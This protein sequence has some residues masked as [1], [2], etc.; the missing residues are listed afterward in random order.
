MGAEELRYLQVYLELKM[1]SKRTRFLHSRLPNNSVIRMLC[2]PGLPQP[3]DAVLHLLHLEDEGPSY[4]RR[5]IFI[6]AQFMSSLACINGGMAENPCSL[7]EKN[8]R[9]VMRNR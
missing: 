7:F 9:Y 3:G 8:T 4:P 5:S 6:M 1:A 2:L